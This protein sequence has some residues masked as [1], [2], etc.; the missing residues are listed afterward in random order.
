MTQISELKTEFDTALAMLQ[1]RIENPKVSIA[2][3][4]MANELTEAN[5][6]MAQLESSLA[7]QQEN[8]LSLSEEYGALE[9][10]I[11]KLK[12][13]DSV[14]LENKELTERLSTLQAKSERKIAAFTQQQLVLKTKISRLN[15]RNAELEEVTQSTAAEPSGPSNLDQIKEQHAHDIESVENIL[16]QLKPLVEG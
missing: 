12:A 3:T 9:L 1:D 10:S 15:A 4:A 5:D 8:Y 13:D 11:N 2:E 16:K 6:K 14:E 7:K